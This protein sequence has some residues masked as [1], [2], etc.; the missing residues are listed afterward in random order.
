[1]FNLRLFKISQNNIN[2]IVDNIVNAWIQDE[3]QG[4]AVIK[5]W[6][7]QPNALLDVAPWF[8][9]NLQRNRLNQILQDTVRNKVQD[10]TKSEAIISQ[11]NQELSNIIPSASPFGELS[12]AKEAPSSDQLVGEGVGGGGSRPVPHC[13]GRTDKRPR[14]RYGDHRRRG[15]SAWVSLRRDARPH[16]DGYLPG[17]CGGHPGTHTPARHLPGIP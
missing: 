16:R 7:T 6:I 5:Q 8:K 17:C 1:M 9:N 11:I 2:T 13:H 3:N 4:K 15:T 14:H 12:Q 10:N